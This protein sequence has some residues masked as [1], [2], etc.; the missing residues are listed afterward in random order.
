MPLRLE[1]GPRDIEQGVVSYMRRDTL[2]KGALPLEGLAEGVK[3]LLDA[4]QDNMYRTALAFNQAHTRAVT[5]YD[6]LREQV[7][8]GYARAMWCGRRA[9]EDRIKEDTGATSRNMP[10]D[11]T[12]H[13]D[14]CVCC[15]QPADKVMYF[16]KAY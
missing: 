10:F 16:S 14:R 9:C 5:S 11:Q 7:Q 3:G 2:E 4:I 13:G 6:E 15:G 12:P 1:L 8:G